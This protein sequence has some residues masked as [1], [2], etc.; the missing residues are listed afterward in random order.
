MPVDEEVARNVLDEVLA[1]QAEDTL[2][3][4]HVPSHSDLRFRC[5]VRT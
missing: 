3:T 5:P 1:P 2:R 4:A